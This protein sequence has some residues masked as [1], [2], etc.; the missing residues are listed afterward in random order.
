MASA[1][2]RSSDTLIFRCRVQAP[3]AA[4][5]RAFTN[6]TALREWLCHIAE[7]DARVGGRLYLWWHSGYYTVGEYVKVAPGRQVV[8][9]W[10]GRGEPAP[11]RVTV[12]LRTRGPATTVTIAHAGLGRGTRWSATRQEFAQAWTAGLNN[13]QSVLETGRDL[14]FTRRPLV[15][16]S[17]LEEINDEIARKLN[18]PGKRGLRLAGVVP[19]MGAAAAGLQADDVL[20]SMAGRKLA[21]WPDLVGALHGCQ[22]GDV[23]PV[24]FYRAGKA[25]TVQLTLSARPLADV[26]VTA[27]GLAESWR[28]VN[29]A[30]NAELDAAVAGLSDEQAGRAPE[31][32]AWSAKQ[33]VAHLIGTERF[34]HFWISH[35]L[36]CTEPVELFTENFPAVINATV[37]AYGTLAALIAE[38]HH[39]Q[40]ETAAIL[41]ALPD[42]FVEQNKGSFWRVAYDLQQYPDHTRTH[43]QQIRAE[44]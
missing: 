39:N 30:L 31:P 4:V 22:A 8:F 11:T 36:Q 13:L 42:E 3:A 23:V 38:L 9:T 1:K 16:V 40:A 21:T 44:I 33:I 6:A 15:G 35:L 19:E 25:H 17:G 14:R 24:R 5:Y 7:V 28:A 2:P 29:A 37:T 43:I 27:A 18:V 41:A 20:V 12:T 10:C 34:L 26:P 32:D